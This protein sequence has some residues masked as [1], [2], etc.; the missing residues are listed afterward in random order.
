MTSP[1]KASIVKKE[2]PSAELTQFR[3]RVAER[4]RYYAGQAKSSN[5]KRAYEG[6]WKRFAQWCDDINVDALPA[7]PEIVAAYLGWLADEG[8]A[9]ST[10]GRAAAAIGKAH[11]VSGY[12]SPTKHPGVKQVMEGVRRSKGAAQKG[13][14]AVLREDLRKMVQVNEG[15][16][17]IDFRNRALLTLGWIAALRRE[18][19]VSIDT[20]HLS[21]EEDRL[22]LLIPKSKTDQEGEGHYIGILKLDDTE[23]CGW[24]HLKAWLDR[25]GIN[26]GPVFVGLK[27]PQ[28]RGRLA[29]QSVWHVVKKSAEKAGLPADIYGAHSLRAGYVT[30]AFYDGARETEIRRVTRHKSEDMTRRYIRP[31]DVFDEIATHR[32]R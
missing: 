10:I 28:A 4:A 13:K 12:F 15:N 14:A 11:E 2:K 24:T 6:D 3:A 20:E 30:Q 19:L 21:W 16:E 18:E 7:E 5:T 32:M 9:S 1:R 8:K 17:L 31:L 23:V 27:G 29:P 22:R 26:Q 25:A